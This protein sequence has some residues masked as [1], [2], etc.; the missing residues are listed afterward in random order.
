MPKYKVLHLITHLERGGAQD[1][2]LLTVEGLDPNRFEVHVAS[3]PGGQWESRTREVAEQFFVIP[4]MKRGIYALSNGRALFEI[5]N[6]LRNQHYHIVHTHSTNAGILGRLAAKLANV[7][8]IVHTV[9]G[10]P[11]DDLT[12][13]P[14]IRTI[15]TYL[16]WFCARLSDKLVMVSELNK[17]QA[18][19][20]GIA[21]VR[22]FEVIHSGIEMARFEAAETQL[23][24]SCLSLNNNWPIVGWIGRL[25]EQNAPEVF[26]LAARRVLQDRPETYF[27]LAGDGHLQAHVERLRGNVPQ[28]KL[29]GYRQ[30][31]PQ[32]LRLFNLFVST[33]RWAGLGRAVTE[34]MI[35]GLP[36]IATC[37]NGVP[38]IVIHQKTGLLVPPND[39]NTVAKQVCYLLDHPEVAARLSHN[40]KAMVIHEFRADLMV[41]RIT[42]LYENLL[43][44]KGLA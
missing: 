34:A 30:D 6:L 23:T 9:H 22:K 36:V 44:Q 2:T 29:L 37:V 35:A 33:V 42:K 10:F 21:P 20:A 32:L 43:A 27:V 13:N 18:L 17:L 11:F 19:K 3:A 16:E 4:S 15:L 12:Y 31:V 25:C 14:V 5:L 7:P 24:R 1:N 38:E 28:I 41:R 40:A 39:P 8:I 26:L